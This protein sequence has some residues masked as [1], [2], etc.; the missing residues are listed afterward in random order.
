MRRL[1]LRMLSM[2]ALLGAGQASALYCVPP[3]TPDPLNLNDVASVML[4][5]TQAFGMTTTKHNT[6]QGGLLR[7]VNS[8][9]VTVLPS[10]S[11]T[12]KTEQFTSTTAETW[13]YTPAGRLTQIDM[14][15]DNTYRPAHIQEKY[16]YDAQGRL[17]RVLYKG[18]PRSAWVTLATCSFSPGG[19]TEHETNV[20]GFKPRTTVYALDVT[21]QVTRSTRTMEGHEQ[22]TD[23]T[24]IT[25]GKNGSVTRTENRFINRST[26][27]N[28][29]STTYNSAGLPVQ[30]VEETYNDAGRLEDA[31]TTT[32]EYVL[33]ARGNW[34]QQLEYIS[35]GGPR[36]L[37]STET[38]TITYAAP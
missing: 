8:K 38:R 7:S 9:S 24:T 6:Y 27:L 18:A 22:D 13:Q 2:L 3:I 28:V 11:S 29:T 4:N 16:E 34:T 33:D 12:T 37:K 5:S 26:P 17:V 36:Q 21:G 19:V 23:V 30:R 14:V 31:L 1:P 20:Q 10:L 35:A 32:F 15:F 25:R